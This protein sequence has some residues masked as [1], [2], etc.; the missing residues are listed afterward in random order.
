MGM[1]GLWAT[2]QKEPPPF[3]ITAQSI[4]LFRF[5]RQLERSC[6][7]PDQECQHWN[8]WWETNRKLAESLG[9]FAGELVF[10]DPEWQW[11][12]TRQIEIDRFRALEG[13][14]IESEERKIPLQMAAVVGR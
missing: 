6:H 8:E 1:R 11:P 3:R 2:P 14:R 10:A 5:M 12:R 9:L 13:R 4:A 7:C